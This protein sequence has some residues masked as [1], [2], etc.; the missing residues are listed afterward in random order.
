MTP[1]IPLFKALRLSAFLLTPVISSPLVR[2]SLNKNIPAG[3]QVTSSG[4]TP[5]NPGNVPQ[6]VPGWSLPSFIFIAANK[7]ACELLK[8]F[9]LQVTLKGTR[10]IICQSAS[11]VLQSHLLL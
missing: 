6:R 1:K 5:G 2:L 9:T 3:A 10:R 11:N 4:S 8:S 7:A